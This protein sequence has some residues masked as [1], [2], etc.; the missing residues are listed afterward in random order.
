MP[1]TLSN[2]VGLYMNPPEVVAEN[3]GRKSTNFQR[4]QP[5]FGESAVRG[6][7]NEARVRLH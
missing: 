4:E 2:A 1:R 7:E 5:I 6:P 3:W